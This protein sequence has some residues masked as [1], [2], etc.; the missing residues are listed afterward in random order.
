MD[1]EVELGEDC[2]CVYQPV[3]LVEDHQLMSPLW[4]CDFFLREAFYS[5]S[6]HIDACESHGE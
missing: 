6:N 4:E 2:A 5:V 1:G 3:C